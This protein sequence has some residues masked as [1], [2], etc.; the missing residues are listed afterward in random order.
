MGGVETRTV[1]EDQFELTLG[2]SVVAALSEMDEISA[3]RNVEVPTKAG[4][5]YTYR[6]ADLA[7]VLGYIRPILAKH[8]LVVAQS[9]QG[10][11]GRASVTTWI[12]HWTGEKLEFG[13]LSM[14]AKGTAQDV[15]SAY[16]YA[17]RYSLMAAMG[18]ATEDDDGQ[19]ASRSSGGSKSADKPAGTAAAPV[20]G[21]AFRTREEAQIMAATA[22][23][24]GDG[25]AEFD[26]AFVEH[27]GST[28][29]DLHKSKH[30][31]AWQWTRVRLEVS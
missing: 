6:Y 27:F 25:R 21:G 18:L 26:A 12:I 14:E 31:L 9:L 1:A 4:G 28:L 23:L 15:G 17:R 13:P 29:A 2:E 24:S 3:T 22:E 10:E 16:T 7:D 30:L 8:G 5:K 19:S 20:A 11:A